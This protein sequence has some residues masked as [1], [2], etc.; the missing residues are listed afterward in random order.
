MEKRYYYLNPARTKPQGP[1]TTTE[2]SNMLLSGVI[3]AATEVAAEGDKCWVPV[4]HVLM[5]QSTLPPLPSAPAAPQPSLPDTA[6][7][8]PPVPGAEAPVPSTPLPPPAT[9]GPAG[10][11]PACGQELLTEGLQLPPSCPHCGHYLRPQ[12]DTMWQCAR[13]AF[14]RP[15][16]WKGRSTRKEF[17]SSF[18]FYMLIYVPLAFIATIVTLVCIHNSVDNIPDR[19]GKHLLE[20]PGMLPAWIA[21]GVMTVLVLYITLV[22]LAVSSRRLHDIGRSAWWLGAYIIVDL[23]WMGLYLYRVYEY[24][25]NINWQLLMAIED[26]KSLDARIQEISDHV[27]MMNYEGWLGLLYLTV[28][29]LGICLFVFSVTDSS[30]GPNK[31][32]PSSKYPL[33]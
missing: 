27:N 18:L 30:P 1:Y 4:G 8:L 25:S 11:C 28:M 14:A 5:S 13:A 10:N 17:W 2:L 3:S 33:N 6:E 20:A 21:I 31:Y 24:L 22:S 26:K 15:F 16:T 7:D 23:S 9:D 32:G 19:L 29:L 12:Q